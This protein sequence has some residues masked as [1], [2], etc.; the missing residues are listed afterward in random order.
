MVNV[1]C[2]EKIDDDLDNLENEINEDFL[3]SGD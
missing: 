2:T 3:K 1:V